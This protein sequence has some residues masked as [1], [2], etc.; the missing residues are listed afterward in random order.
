MNQHIQNAGPVL[1]RAEEEETF[2]YV[3]F[4]ASC[5]KTLRNV[6]VPSF[7]D[8]KDETQAVNEI[9]RLAG[10]KKIHL[11]ISEWLNNTRAMQDLIHIAQKYELPAV[12][13]RAES[14]PKIGRIVVSTGGGP[15]RYNQI[16]LAREISARNAVPVT[17]L[18]WT[19]A[20]NRGSEGTI[21]ENRRFEKMCRRLLGKQEEFLQCNGPDFASAVAGTLRPD[22]LLIIGATSP[23]RLVTD[24]YGSLPDQL[25]R[26]IPNPLIM[27]SSPPLS[28]PGLRRHLWSRIIQP[29]RIPGERKAP[30]PL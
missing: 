8:P 26:A 12:F 15:N 3:N 14:A 10:E 19:G 24:F 11:I 17:I 21:A 5:N 25:A 1:R 7:S 20:L 28:L 18:H 2:G 27:W 9:Y 4:L 6:F 30:S 13:V 22:D 29:L 23:F 16:K